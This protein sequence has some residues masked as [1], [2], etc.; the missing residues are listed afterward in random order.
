MAQSVSHTTTDHDTIRKWAEERGGWPAQV[1]STEQGGRAGIIRIDFPGYTGEGKLERISWDEWFRKL[2]ESNLAL[3]YEETTAEGQRSS[4]NKLVRREAAGAQPEGVP[5]P[6][7][8]RKRAAGA[9]TARA[10]GPK[11]AETGK[12][13]GRKTPARAAGAAKAGGRRMERGEGRRQTSRA[14]AARTAGRT[15]RRGARG[16]KPLKAKSRTT[17]RAGG[18]GRGG[19]RSSRRSR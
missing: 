9:R 4:F 19:G 7:R 11:A 1:A 6:Q 2:D 14:A 18:G 8:P 17:S 5:A 13:A 15:G 10:G 3:V 16:G 12:R